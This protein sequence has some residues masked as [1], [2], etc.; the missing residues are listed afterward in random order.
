MS[1]AGQ[2]IGKID[3]A[4]KG[5]GVLELDDVG[6]EYSGSACL[7]SYDQRIP[8]TEAVIRVPKVSIDRFEAPIFALD[9]SGLRLD[10]LQMK[11]RFPEYVHGDK[12]EI[13]FDFDDRTVT[14]RYRTNLPSIGQGVLE[15][16]TVDRGRG[17]SPVES[18]NTWRKFREYLETIDVE[19]FIFRGQPGPFPLRTAFH[20]TSRSDLA[21]Y[22]D[23]DAQYLERN[24]SPIVAHRFDF[25]DPGQ[26]GNYLNLVQHHGY[27]TPLLDWTESPYV[28]GYFAYQSNQEHP[29]NRVRILMLEK[30]P[31]MSPSEVPVFFTRVPPH[32]TIMYLGGFLNPRMLP[33]HSVNMLTNVDD[34]EVY[35]QQKDAVRGRKT[36]T[37]FDLPFS[38][39]RDTLAHLRT[40]GITAGS[41]FP[42]LDGSCEALKMERF[43]DF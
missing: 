17:I 31:W 40:M 35:I 6:D 10:L 29:S 37:A 13:A 28:A 9:G 19:K 42:G 1:L 16:R 7:Y 33:Q 22:L 20:R 18:V 26:F 39:R 23:E 14:L 4:V 24:L 15:R 32:I 27:P 38:E 3:G 21:R 12:V 5:M 11:E 36:L 25:R 41:L 2:W 43:D 30:E 8:S 34:I